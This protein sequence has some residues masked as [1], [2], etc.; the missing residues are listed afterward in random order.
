[1]QGQKTHRRRWLRLWT[2]RAYQTY[3]TP[4]SPDVCPP[5]RSS[6]LGSLRDSSQMIAWPPVCRLALPWGC[7]I[8]EEFC[9]ALLPLLGPRHLVPALWPPSWPAKRH[10]MN[11]LC[12][13]PPGW[14]WSQR[15]VQ[16][17]AFSWR[18]GSV[19]F[20]SCCEG[21]EEESWRKSSCLDFFWVAWNPWCL[22][23]IARQSGS[24]WSRP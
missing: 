10:S 3:A 21:P 7:C 5:R 12:R 11:P 24:V 18:S 6:P 1:M 2:C 13:P 22:V 9:G 4:Q 20:C 14:W 17:A 19:A 23:Q 16:A 8:A 15:S